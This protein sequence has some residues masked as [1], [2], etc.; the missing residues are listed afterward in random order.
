MT[1]LDISRTLEKLAFFMALKDENEFKISACLKAARSVRDCP[2][3][4]EDLLLA[5][6]SLTRID[7]VG[8]ILAKKIEDL[9]IFGEIRALSELL[10]E[11]PEKLFEIN[12]IRGI[13]A[14]TVRR[15]WQEHGIV[16]LEE[17]R[18]HVHGGGA[19]NVAPAMEQRIRDFLVP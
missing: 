13:G 18:R 15:L 1:N 4:V 7:G 12:Q 3:E 5:G 2:D 11:F 6:E 14:K 16:S 10:K 8:K 17:L 19:L 9:V